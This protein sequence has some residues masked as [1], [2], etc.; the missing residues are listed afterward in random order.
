MTSIAVLVP[1]RHPDWG[2]AVDDDTYRTAAEWRDA[3]RK[4]YEQRQGLYA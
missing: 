2:T 3:D 4:L 1:T